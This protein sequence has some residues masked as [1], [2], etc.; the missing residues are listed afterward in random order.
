MVTELNK[1]V[2]RKV[3]I[4]GKGDFVVSITKDGITIR[5]FRKRKT[6][7]LPFDQLALRAL[8]QAAYLLNEKE[9]DDPLETLGKLGRLKR[10]N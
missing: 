2:S 10:K 7:T 1:P 5:K 9:W 8:E 3:H 6:V 4:R